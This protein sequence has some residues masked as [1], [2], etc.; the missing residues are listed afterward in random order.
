MFWKDCCSLN[1][2]P[3]DACRSFRD[4]GFCLAIDDFGT[5]YSSL[6]YLQRLPAQIV[7]IDQTFIRDL[8]IA[9]GP[10]FELAETMI[11]LAHKLGYRV[12]AEGV[13]TAEAAAI[14]KELGCEE[15]Q[16]FWFA[17]PMEADRFA[18]WL[19]ERRKSARPVLCA[20]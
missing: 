2:P 17:R 6:A 11:S 12:V 18:T 16:G 19:S 10:D 4:A 15:A 8:T 5:G 3:G 20:A 1:R 7:K 14:L 9:E 13:E